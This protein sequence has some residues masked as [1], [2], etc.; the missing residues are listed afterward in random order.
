MD[1]K[2][3]IKNRRS[4]RQFADEDITPEHVQLILRAALMSPTSKG[5]R[6]WQ[7]AVVDNKV[8]IEKIS[9]A[10]ETGSQFLKKA[11]LCIVVM[12]NPN[13]NDCWIED[14]SIAA[15]S[16][17]LQAED[18]GLGGCWVQMRGRGLNDGTTAQAVIHGILDI[19]D[20]LEVL[21]VVGIGHK[22][23]QREPQDEDGLKWER[24]TIID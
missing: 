13:E 20:N 2:E 8:N 1:F 19:P 12:G 7:F 14:G 4:Y 21:C 17:L 23:S 10:K 6:A 15:Y 5:R 18:L 24:V 16:M 11:P 3:L 22:V 9:D